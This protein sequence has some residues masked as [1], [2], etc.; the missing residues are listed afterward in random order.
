MKGWVMIPKGKLKTSAQYKR[1][2]DQGLA[3][4]KTLPPK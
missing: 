4:A 3:F 2:L 1:W